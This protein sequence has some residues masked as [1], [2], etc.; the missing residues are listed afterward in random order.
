MH[1][2]AHYEPARRAASL[3]LTKLLASASTIGAIWRI[4][5]NWNVSQI[6][7][8]NSSCAQ[9]LWDGQNIISQ[10]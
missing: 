9:T 4:W 8:C 3:T 2:K 7:A 1:G 10:L 6:W 5:F